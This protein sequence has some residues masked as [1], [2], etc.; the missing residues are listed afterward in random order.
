[1]GTLST[2]CPPIQGEPRG[3]VKNPLWPREEDQELQASLSNS[4]TV[5]K[6]DKGWG[7]SSG[8]PRLGSTPVPDTPPVPGAWSSPRRAWHLRVLPEGPSA[9]GARTPAQGR[10]GWG[11]W[12]GKDTGH[13]LEGW[14]CSHRRWRQEPR[15]S[16]WGFSVHC[17]TQA[18][19]VW[20]EGSWLWAGRGSPSSDLAR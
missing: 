6:S 2:L 9:P 7:C 3:L 5:S 1:M 16:C 17:G 12:E 14:S 15:L 8:E 11:L 13:Q 10:L 4:G 18:L 19:S 20:G